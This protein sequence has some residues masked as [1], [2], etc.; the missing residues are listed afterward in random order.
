MIAPL[1]ESNNKEEIGWCPIKVLEAMAASKPV[2]VSDVSG[3]RE[4]LSDT[5]GIITHDFAEAIQ[6]LRNK[7][8]REKKGKAAREKIEKELSW[9][10]TAQK[11]VRIYKRE[12]ET[13]MS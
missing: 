8:L 4:I 9:N 7:D 11:L 1:K 13:K 5:E 6:E 12:I 10:H 3:I 2:I